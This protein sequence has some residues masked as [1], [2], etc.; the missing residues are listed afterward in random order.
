MNCAIS[1]NNVQTLFTSH[2]TYIGYCSIYFV[3]K[4]KRCFTGHCYQYCYL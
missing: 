3:E 4:S 1:F 2:S